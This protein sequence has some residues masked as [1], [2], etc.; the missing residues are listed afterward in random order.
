[1]R[2][3]TCVRSSQPTHDVW[4]R[5]NCHALSC[6]HASCAGSC[7][8]SNRRENIARQTSSW[9]RASFASPKSQACVA[10]ITPCL[11]TQYAW[12]LFTERACDH[13]WLHQTHELVLIY[14][15]ALLIDHPS[16]SHQDIRDE[17][18]TFPLPAMENEKIKCFV[19]GFAFHARL[20]PVPE[21]GG[22]ISE[23]PRDAIFGSEEGKESRDSEH[24]DR[25]KT[26]NPFRLA[27]REARMKRSAEHDFNR[28]NDDPLDWYAEIGAHQLSASDQLLGN[29][30]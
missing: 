1:M 3:L 13:S 12:P 7:Q 10:L 28:L 23:S 22:R 20:D 19:R 6:Q 5:L 16:A 17:L 30:R 9:I 25:E 21:G 18:K 26:S 11:S 27:S 15:L 2:P 29:L 14:L 24:E 8:K 4:L